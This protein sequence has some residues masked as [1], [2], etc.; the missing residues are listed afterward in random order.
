MKLEINQQ[1]VADSLNP[2]NLAQFIRALPQEDEATIALWKSDQ[3]M[4]QAAG[5]PASGFVVNYQHTREKCDWTS[6]NQ[7]LKMQTVLRALTA[8]ARSEPSWKTMFAWN[9]SVTPR[10]AKWFDIPPGLAALLI[11]API[12]LIALWY[13]GQSDAPGTMPFHA[14][15]PRALVGVTLIAGYTQWVDVFL[16]YIRPRAKFALM[17]FF[18]VNIVES[19]PEINILTGTPISELWDVQGTASLG[20]RAFVLIADMVIL[21]GGFVGPILVTCVPLFLLAER[22]G[23]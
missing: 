8:F 12:T 4:L 20:V 6:A 18:G 17:N 13:S 14:S 7:A 16:R 2:D 19:K 15:A 5:V 21:L 22:L 9:T 3:E 11:F 10:W 1:V 23:W